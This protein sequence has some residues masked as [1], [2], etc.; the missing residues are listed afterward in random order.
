[1]SETNE[2]LRLIDALDARLARW[3]QSDNTEGGTLIALEILRE[4]VDEIRRAVWEM[5]E[6]LRET[7]SSTGTV[8]PLD[9]PPDSVVR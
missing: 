6:E 2:T 3:F 8:Q 5:E 4:D 9:S 1:M 7:R